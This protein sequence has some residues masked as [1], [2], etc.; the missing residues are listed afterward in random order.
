MRFLQKCIRRAGI[1]IRYSD[2]VTPRMIMSTAMPLGL[3]HESSGEYVD[4]ELASRVTTRQALEKLR[5]LMPEGLEIL[6][7]RQ[8]GD[9]VP[10][11]GGGEGKKKPQKA[12]SI[13]AAA[14]Y[15]VRFRGTYRRSGLLPPDWRQILRDFVAQDTIP[16]TKETKRGFRTLDM[17]P[18]IYGIYIEDGVPDP[19]NTVAAGC[20]T[21][22]GRS[23]EGAVSGRR[24]ELY[25]T[26]SC[27]SPCAPLF[28]EAVSGRQK[29]LYGTASGEKDPRIFMCV[30]SRVGENLRPEQLIGEAFRR[31]GYELPED[32]LRIFRL[33]LLA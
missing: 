5:P 28:F 17:K 13:V 4:M 21:L 24:K 12:M 19:E 33:D 2:G 29:E 6:D 22:D 10:A 27:S 3:G 25:R 8:L 26:H 30:C 15:E 11:G 9:P 1:P 16:W 31:K 20:K 18:L 14:E 23:A 7:F 32:A